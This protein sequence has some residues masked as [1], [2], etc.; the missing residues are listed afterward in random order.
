MQQ[1]LVL[2]NVQSLRLHYNTHI[3]MKEENYDVWTY[4]WTTWRAP[5]GILVWFESAPM[6]CPDCSAHLVIGP[7]GQDEK[8]A[9]EP[10]NDSLYASHGIHRSTIWNTTNCST[11]RSTRE[12]AHGVRDIEPPLLQ[13]RN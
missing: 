1:V 12:S 9:L 5:I 10:T 2:K 4:V 3:P 13:W 6:D 8:D 11:T 7:L